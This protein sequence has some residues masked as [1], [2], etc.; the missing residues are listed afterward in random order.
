MANFDITVRIKDKLAE[1][2]PDRK[3]YSEN[4][5]GNFKDGT[6]FI[7][8]TKLIPTPKLFGMQKQVY[9]LQIVYFPLEE[10]RRGD[11]DNVAEKLARDFK[12]LDGVAHL[13]NREFVP[14]D[15]ELHFSFDL[16]V[17]ILPDEVDKFTDDLDF[18]G[19][20]KNGK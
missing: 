17:H 15:D 12:V 13:T 14:L 20:I 1:L 16:E 3:I 5:S 10:D 19:G 8:R 2:F 9:S 18:I 11:M 6:F 7:Q 4:I